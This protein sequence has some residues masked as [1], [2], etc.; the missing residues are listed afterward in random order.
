LTG[1]FTKEEDEALTIAVKK[2]GVDEFQ[3]IKQEMNSKRSIS[4]LRT[5][6]NNFLDPNVDRSPWTK[7]EKEIAVKLFAELKNIRA[8]KLKMNSKRSIRDMYNQLRNK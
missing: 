7:E 8:V 4:Q 2:Y 3:K 5:R 1:E 6:Y